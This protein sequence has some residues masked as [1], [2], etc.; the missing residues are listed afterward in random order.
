MIKYLCKKRNCTALVEK[1]GEYCKRHESLA[2]EDAKHWTT[3]L[4]KV[5]QTFHY[6]YQTAEWKE[7]KRRLL[8]DTLCVVCGEPAKALDHI[9][10]HRGNEQLFFDESN[11]QPLCSR[12]HSH[13]T[14]SEV[15]QRQLGNGA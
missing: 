15:R 1:R 4:K 10:A 13:K 14:L 9:I 12:C 5:E 6:L 11:L 7:I 8:K 2:V 3:K